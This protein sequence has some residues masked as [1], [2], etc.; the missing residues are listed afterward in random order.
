MESSIVRIVIAMLS[1]L[2]VIPSDL[3]KQ[4]IIDFFDQHFKTKNV[5]FLVE[6]GSVDNDNYIGII[7]RVIGEN[8]ENQ[9]KFSIIVKVA[10]RE[11]FSAQLA[12]QREILIYSE[13]YSRFNY[14][15]SLAKE[16]E[17]TFTRIYFRFLNFSKNGIN[18]EDGFHE[19]PECYATDETDGHEVILMKDLRE[20]K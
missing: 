19:Y 16:H 12:F 9:E 6:N 7:H 15:F 4:K 20:K 14:N 3:V 11:R 8:I 2:S 17:I 10:R 5:K 18:E 1:D 13:A